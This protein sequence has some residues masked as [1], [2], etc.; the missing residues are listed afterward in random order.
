MTDEREHEQ[1]E[2]GQAERVLVDHQT[3][4]TRAHRLRNIG[5]VAVGKRVFF[6]FVAA[7]LFSGR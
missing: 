4:T 7:F 3:P 1:R 6:N 2:E 5:V